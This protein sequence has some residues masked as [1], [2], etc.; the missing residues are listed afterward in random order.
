MVELVIE[1]LHVAAE[2]NIT[3]SN[4]EGKEEYSFEIY[5]PGTHFI[6]H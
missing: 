3:S 5:I 6:D 1:L 4:V 2:A